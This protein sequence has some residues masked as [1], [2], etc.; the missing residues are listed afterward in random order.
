MNNLAEIECEYKKE[1][2]LS[3]ILIESDKI[4]LPYFDQVQLKQGILKESCEFSLTNGIFYEVCIHK[5]RYNISWESLCEYVANKLKS[6]Q[7]LP[8]SLSSTY[9]I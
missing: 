3:L 4:Y 5:D 6:C 7:I 2:I 1:K 8:Q 9:S